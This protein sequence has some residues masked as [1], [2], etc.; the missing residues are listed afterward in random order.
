MWTFGLFLAVQFA[1]AVQTVSGISRFGPA[2]E[3]NPIL[4][5]YVAALALWPR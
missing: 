5:F 3:A 4:S 2:I 1:D